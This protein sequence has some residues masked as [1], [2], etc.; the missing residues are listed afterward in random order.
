MATKSEKRSAARETFPIVPGTLLLL[1]GLT[2]IT[3]TLIEWFDHTSK[4]ALAT[5][6][7]IFILLGALPFVGGVIICRRVILAVRRRRFERYETEILTLA[8]K[9]DR[10]LTAAEVAAHTELPLAEAHRL[11]DHYCVKGIAKL[12]IS[13]SGVKVYWFWELISEEEKRHAE[14]V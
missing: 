8:K 4:H 3:G 6:L 14:T 2:M 7:T 1:F 5:D 9:M 11:L 12:E 10:R 13:D